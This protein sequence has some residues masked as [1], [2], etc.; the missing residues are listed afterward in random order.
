MSIT[1]DYKYD[2]WH[3]IE[4]RLRLE[5]SPTITSTPSSD[6]TISAPSSSSD[7]ISSRSSKS[8]LGIPLS[9]D[10]KINILGLCFEKLMR[11][12]CEKSNYLHP[13]NLLVL[14]L[15]D[16]HWSEWF[17]KLEL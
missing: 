5:K 8:T 2:K 12:F 11:D 1:V 6:E 16:D 7:T 17:T 10:D 4:K 14:D 3:I 13:E 15:E 9:D